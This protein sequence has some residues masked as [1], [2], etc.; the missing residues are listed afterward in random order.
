M[1]VTKSLVHNTVREI[2]GDQALPVVDYLKNRKNI[3]EFIIAEKMNMHINELRNMLYKLFEVNLAHYYKKKDK[4]KGW[5]I[6]YWTLN[7]HRVRNVVNDMKKRKLERLQQRLEEEIRYKDNFY[8]CPNICIRVPF[9]TAFETNFKCTECG[10]IMEQQE[11]EK[12]IQRLQENISELENELKLEAAEAKPVSSPKAA[13]KSASRPKQKISPKPQKKDSK[14]PKNV[15]K[16]KGKSAK[17]TVKKAE[18][19]EKKPKK[20]KILGLFCF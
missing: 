13:A 1:K 10:A 5:Y 12:T 8:L 16:A 15:R 19:A 11:S 20:K 4:K 14:N 2:A 6:S 18:Q 9:D 7:L 17:K 3:S